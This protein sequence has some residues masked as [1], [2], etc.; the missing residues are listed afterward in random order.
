MSTID[1]HAQ[2]SDAPF[3]QSSIASVIQSLNAIRG[4]AGVTS[5]SSGQTKCGYPAV[6]TAHAI[7]S[8][9]TTEE[10]AQVSGLMSRPSTHTS[11]VSLSG[12][13]RIHYDT[14]GVETVPTLDADFSGKP[15]YVERAAVCLDSSASRYQALGFVKP[16][17]DGTMGGDSLYDVYFQKISG[18]GVTFFDGAGPQTWD[19]ELSYI[20]LHHTFGGFPPNNDPEGDSLGALKV[21]CAHEYFHAVQLAYDKNDDLWFYES[22][23]TY[24]EERLFPEVDDNFQ[25]LPAFYADPDTFLTTSVG[26]HPYGAFVWPLFLAERHHDSL[27]RVYWEKSRFLPG[28]TAQDSALLA[29]GD[30]TSV[31]FREFARWNLFTGDRANGLCFGDAALYPGVAIDQIIPSAPFSSVNG[32]QTPD[33]FA[34]NYI[35]LPLGASAPGLLRLDFTGEPVVRWG[36]GLWYKDSVGAYDYVSS[37]A[38]IA[39]ALSH[40][41]FNYTRWDTLI[42]APLVVSPYQD[43]NDYT[44]D[45]TVF[46]FGDAN[47]SGGVDIGDVTYLIAYIFSAGAGPVYDVLLGDADCSSDINISDVTHIIAYIF[48]GGPAPCAP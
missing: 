1:V 10:Q 11:L 20:V 16:P 4:D 7:W 21:T 3:E 40:T 37:V 48:S 26:S 5:P 42:I 36:L 24:H 12:K 22:Q 29:F 19:D 18:Y 47:G 32:T 27:I 28:L 23:A 43:D 8:K 33:G 2:K 30:S 9:M 34:V 14:S 13:F 44:L 6:W 17:S 25:F 38:P 41:R 35:L 31:A 46:P 45:A 15:D 39:G